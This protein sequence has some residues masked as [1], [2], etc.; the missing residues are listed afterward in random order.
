MNITGIKNID[1]Y[2][3][4]II[5]KGIII[6]IFG[7]SG[8]GKTLLSMQISINLLTQCCGNILYYDTTG[9]FRPERLVEIIHHNKLNTS[10]LDRITVGRIINTMEQINYT[11]KIFTSQ[12]L[13]LII[14]DNITD[15]FSFE[16]RNKNTIK[17]ILLMKYM[18][19]ISY[20]ASQKKIPTL[21]INNIF[22]NNETENSHKII[23]M[24]THI[25]IKLKKTNTYS[26]KLITPWIEKKFTYMISAKGLIEI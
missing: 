7:A 14:I 13:S 4:I 3:A 16:Y 17:N 20:I 8:T 26:G 18:R 22:D 1:P 6:D 12:K 25:K 21:I 19:N 23:D 15:L 2:L 9:Q 5:D 24:F 10:L 11:E